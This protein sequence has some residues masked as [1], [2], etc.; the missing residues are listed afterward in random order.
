MQ[1][2]KELVVYLSPDQQ[3]LISSLFDLSADPAAEERAHA[4]VVAQSLTGPHAP[5]LGNASNPSTV[6][7]FSD[8][9]CPYCAKL[10]TMLDSYR[11]Q[12]KDE[13]RVLFRQF[14]LDFH[15]W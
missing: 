5:A 11:A 7:V 13:A 8:F 2:G 14:P 12:Y 4:A 15:P 10:A 1:S 6:V 9:Q 3:F